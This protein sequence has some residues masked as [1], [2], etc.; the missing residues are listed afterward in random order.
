MAAAPATFCSQSNVL[1][2][3][4]WCYVLEKGGWLE[5]LP[6]LQ[7][8]SWPKQQGRRNVF[9]SLAASPVCLLSE[10]TSTELCFVLLIRARPPHAGIPNAVMD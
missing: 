6:R 9:P 2:I 8:G 3:T 5:H 7:G 1:G 4:G 10:S